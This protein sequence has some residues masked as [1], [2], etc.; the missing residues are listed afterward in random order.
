M[1]VNTSSAAKLLSI[2][3]SLMHTEFQ[4]I[5]NVLCDPNLFG[6]RTLVGFFFFLTI[7]TCYGLG[8][9]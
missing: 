3:R 4:E 5:Q 1:K 7:T 6:Q 8:E 2:C 9:T